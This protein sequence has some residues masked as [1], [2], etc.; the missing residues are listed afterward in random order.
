MII[1]WEQK[2]CNQNKMAKEWDRIQNLKRESN[3][4]EKHGKKWIQ[5]IKILKLL[6]NVAFS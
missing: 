1:Q 4:A 6:L 3:I 5:T 2:K